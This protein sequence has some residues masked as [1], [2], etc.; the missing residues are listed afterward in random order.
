M[1]R[2]S[3]AQTPETD[4]EYRAIEAALLESARGRWFLAE[5]GRR[6]RRLDSALLE[7]A[8]GRLQTSLRLDL[9]VFSGELFSPCGR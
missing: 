1:H 7:D 2:L 5:H 6:A 4:D 9:P 3:H 8:I